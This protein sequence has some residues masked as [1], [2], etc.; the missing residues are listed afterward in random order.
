MCECVYILDF[1]VSLVKKY[2]SRASLH[3]PSQCRRA[4]FKC[5]PSLLRERERVCKRERESVGMENFSSMHEMYV[6]LSLCFSLYVSLSLCLILC[7]HA[8]VC[9]FVCVCVCVCERERERERE[10]CEEE[11]VLLL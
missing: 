9:A 3:T 6:F 7:M 2:I 8:C 10:I 4:C 5:V 1:L 11:K